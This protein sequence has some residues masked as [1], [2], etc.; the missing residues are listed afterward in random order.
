MN[1]SAEDVVLRFLTPAPP[2]LHDELR[3]ALAA[4]GESLAEDAILRFCLDA[5][6]GHGALVGACAGSIA[7]VSAHI[8]E[9]WV[10]ERQRGRGIGGALLRAVEDEALQRRCTRVH[11]ETRSEAARRLYER[12][13]YRAFG[14]L[15]NYAGARSLYYLEKRLTPANGGV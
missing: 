3:R 4:T 5:R 1:A 15:D 7:F 8:S 2:T 11:L 12:R 14:E 10:D 13:G 6:D 9:L